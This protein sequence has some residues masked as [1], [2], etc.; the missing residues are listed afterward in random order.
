MNC[1]FSCLFTFQG[2]QNRRNNSVWV[3]EGEEIEAD[4]INSQIDKFQKSVI[5]YGQKVLRTFDVDIKGK[6]FENCFQ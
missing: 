3:E 4:S 5:R 2:F 6:V 1:D